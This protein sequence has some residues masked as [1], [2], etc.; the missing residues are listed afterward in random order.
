MRYTKAFI[1]LSGTNSSET[2]MSGFQIR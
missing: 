2:V 1:R